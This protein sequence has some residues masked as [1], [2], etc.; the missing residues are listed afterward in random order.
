MRSPVNHRPN[1]FTPL[2]EAS[3]LLSR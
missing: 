3:H 1:T 2:T